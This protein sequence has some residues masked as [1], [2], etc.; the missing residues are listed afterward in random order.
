MATIRVNPDD[1]DPASIKRAA[2]IIRA[3]GLVAFPTETVYGLG[4][5]ALDED[6]VYGIF[7]IKGRPFWDPLI[8][9][10]SSTDMVKL[11]AKSIPDLFH[12]LSERFMPGPLT[13]VVEKSEIVPD[14][15]TAGLPTVAVRIP[16]HPVALALIRESGV[17]IAAPSANRFGR[18]SPTSA[19]H[20]LEDFGDS[21]D[22]LLDGGETKIGVESTV[23]DITRTPPVLLRP[24]G[25]SKEEIEEVVGRVEVFRGG[26]RAVPSPGM[27]PRH[28]APHAEILLVD[29]GDPGKAAEDMAKKASGLLEKGLK[30]GVIAPDE[31]T[32]FISNLPIS[33]R[34]TGR[35]GE[36]D[37]MAR[38]LFRELRSLDGEGV[39][40][41]ICILPPPRGIGLAIRDR[42]IRASFRK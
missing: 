27:S 32:S 23:L 12:P 11:V 18:P 40:A 39:D 42:L 29:E 10:L 30:V 2:E 9:H 16:S 7:L 31:V 35:W 28:Y 19:H 5:N 6:A 13:L 34:K 8:V 38:R 22:L 14:I 21:I 36:W 25:V 15:T 4:A 41:I 24:G 37:E 33:V 20:V 1:P 17:P 26:T 3:G